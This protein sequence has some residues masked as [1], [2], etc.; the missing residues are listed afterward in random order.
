MT[1]SSYMSLR[2]SAK[3]SG[4]PDGFSMGGTTWRV[5]FSACWICRSI[6]RTAYWYS[7]SLRR[8][9]GPRR[10]ISSLLR[11]ATT[12][13]IEVRSCARWA[14]RA[15]SGV[16]SS[17]KRRSKARRGFVSGGMGVVA[18]RQEMLLVYAQ[19]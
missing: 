10:A 12:S 3:V 15:G 1:W 2:Y 16:S 17:P 11:S 8:S 4:I 19:L 18:A 5:S 13:R 14:R 9:G 7:S 6:S